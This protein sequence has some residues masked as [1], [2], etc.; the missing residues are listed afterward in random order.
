[1]ALFG[2]KKEEKKNETPLKEVNAAV[3]K[4]DVSV[5]GGLPKHALSIIRPRITEKA[6]LATDNNV[7]VFEVTQDSTKDTVKEAIKALYKVEPKKVH[8]VRMRPRKFV[9]RMRGRRGIKPGFKKA[10]VY[11]KKGDTIEFA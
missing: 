4:K 2:N 5:K 3:S 11:L 6:T 10:Y 8:M 9:S 1:M 7:Y